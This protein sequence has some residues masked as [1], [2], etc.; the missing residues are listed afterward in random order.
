MPIWLLGE[1]RWPAISDC[2][3]ICV[4]CICLYYFNQYISSLFCCNLLVSQLLCWKLFHKDLDFHNI[5]KNIFL[6]EKRSIKWMNSWEFREN[7]CKIKKEEKIS[8]SFV[9]HNLCYT[10]EFSS[11]HMLDPVLI[12]CLQIKLFHAT[13][14]SICCL[15]Q[16]QLS[17]SW[18]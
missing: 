14:K 5:K 1:N 15:F 12:L 2:L 16:I 3:G 6:S 11:L 10:F 8:Q 17:L 7:N 4:S 9:F 13:S 18:V